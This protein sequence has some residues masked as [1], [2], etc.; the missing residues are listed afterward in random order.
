MDG[1]WRLS[2]RAA[3]AALKR[4]DF[5]ARDLLESCLGRIDA[6]DP[7]VHA[8]ITLCIDRARAEAQASDERRDAG[9]ADR[10]L[11]GLPFAVKDLAD[12]ADVR[13][14]YGSLA[15]KDHVERGPVFH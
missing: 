14:T 11:E 12:T 9:H 4:R 2:A 7:A 5:S 1:P 8:F 13:T 10:P 3:L 6:L 15:F